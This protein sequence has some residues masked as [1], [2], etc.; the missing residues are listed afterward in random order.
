M[1]YVGW[2]GHVET[3]DSVFTDLLRT[4]G[5]VFYG[6]HDMFFGL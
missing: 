4:L 3:N 5:A 2:L 6:P 1:C